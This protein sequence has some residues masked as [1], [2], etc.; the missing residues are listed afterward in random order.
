MIAH[1]N[2][3][4]RGYVKFKGGELV[5]RLIGKVV[6]GFTMPKREDLDDNDESNWE[7]NDRGERRDP[8][9]AQSYLPLENL[10]TGE[11]VVFAR[12]DRV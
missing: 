1:V 6:D 8:W 2:Q 5:D 12:S 10:E 9:V 7:M 3:L 11:L 4:A